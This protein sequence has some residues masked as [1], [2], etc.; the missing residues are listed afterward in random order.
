MLKSLLDYCTQCRHLIYLELCVY[1]LSALLETPHLQLKLIYISSFMRL[2]YSDSRIF[3]RHLIYLEI[4]RISTL[5]SGRDTS[6]TVK[7]GAISSYCVLFT[8]KLLED[9]LFQQEYIWSLIEYL[10]SYRHP[11][12]MMKNH[13]NSYS[14]FP[15]LSLFNISLPH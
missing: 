4:I 6:F 9:S 2:I 7:V 3:N 11:V 12:S 8:P 13:Y 15:R 1:P 14:S 5:C 10:L